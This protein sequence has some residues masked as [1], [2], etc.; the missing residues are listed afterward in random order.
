MID[1]NPNNWPDITEVRRD[2]VLASEALKSQKQGLM[3]LGGIAIAA[4]I[5]AL[6]SRD[7]G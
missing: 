6:L 2:L 4:V 5:A 7:Q 3:V 1:V